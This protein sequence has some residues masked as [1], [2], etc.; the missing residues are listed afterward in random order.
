M[1][2]IEGPSLE[3][4]IE[5]LKKPPTEHEFLALALPILAAVGYAHQQGIIHR[6][7]SPRTSCSRAGPRG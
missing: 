3:A 1:E 7:I 2:L 5:S 4:Y 6:D